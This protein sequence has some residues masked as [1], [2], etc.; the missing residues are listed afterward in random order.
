MDCKV[1]GCLG[2]LT[3]ERDAWLGDTAGGARVSECS[4]CGALFVT[5]V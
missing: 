1:E 4:V 3:R 5:E 2:V